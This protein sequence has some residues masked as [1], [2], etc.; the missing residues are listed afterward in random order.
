MWPADDFHD[1]QINQRFFKTTNRL[2]I[3]ILLFL[4][5]FNS[6][7]PGSGWLRAYQHDNIINYYSEPAVMTNTCCFHEFISFALK[8]ASYC[9][10]TMYQSVCC[11]S[12]FLKYSKKKELKV[13]NGQKV[14]MTRNYH[15][16][17]LQNS[18]WHLK[19]QPDGGTPTRQWAGHP[20]LPTHGAHH[21]LYARKFQGCAPEL[22]I[23]PL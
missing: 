20:D 13:K 1:L 3:Q 12:L 23:Y 17:I 5:C 19:A 8:L 14:D 6:L 11:V 18:A 9:L 22:H 10:L 2:L 15:N 16:H 7:I 21:T 4:P